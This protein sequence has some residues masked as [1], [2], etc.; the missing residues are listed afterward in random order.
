MRAVGWKHGENELTGATLSEA[1]RFN[2]REPPPQQPSQ[3]GMASALLG[4][5]SVVQH[6]GDIDVGLVVLH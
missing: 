4:S 2:G 1:M 3:R 5:A 6:Q